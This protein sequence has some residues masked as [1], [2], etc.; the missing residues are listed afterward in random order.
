M[1]GSGLTLEVHY[2]V[3]ASQT[4]SEVQAASERKQT[5]HLKSHT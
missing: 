1:H 3:S 2:S 4:A 5:H